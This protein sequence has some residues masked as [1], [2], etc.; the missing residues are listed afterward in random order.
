MP[1]IWEMSSTSTYKTIEVLRH[2]F[3]VFGLP[4]Q[5]VS[6]NGPQFISDQFS[7]FLRSNGIK[8]FKS[9]PYHRSTNGAAERL[10]QTFKKA[11]KKG[12]Q[13]GFSSQIY[14]F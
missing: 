4:E 3:S 11:I 7:S 13:D 8:H 10:V 9:A 14:S 5:V 2:I 1:E 6:D 12:K